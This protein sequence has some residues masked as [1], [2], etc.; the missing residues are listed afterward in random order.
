M[1]RLLGPRPLATRLKGVKLRPEAAPFGSEA[2]SRAKAC[3]YYPAA[4]N[5]G[6]DAAGPETVNTGPEAVDGGETC[7]LDQRTL[8]LGL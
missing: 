1:L 4:V 3:E 8:I 6:P 5:T 7:D 2:L